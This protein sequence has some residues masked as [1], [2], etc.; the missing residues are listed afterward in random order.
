MLSPT[1][2]IRVVKSIT[3]KEILRLRPEVKQKLWGGEFWTKGY[4]VNTLA[5]I[6]TT[7]QFSNISNLRELR[8]NTKSFICS[9]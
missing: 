9:S 6:G 4:Y 2:I 3:A 7:I 1:Q 5:D 8:K